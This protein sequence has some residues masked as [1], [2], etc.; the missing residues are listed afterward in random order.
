M[1]MASSTM[2]PCFVARGRVG[3]VVDPVLLMCCILG[4]GGGMVRPSVICVCVYCDVFGFVD[5]LNE[6]DKMR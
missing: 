3:Y 5:R 4:G 6:V 1:S 2:S